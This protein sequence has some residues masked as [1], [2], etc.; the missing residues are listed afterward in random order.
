MGKLRPP[1]APSVDYQDA[2]DWLRGILWLDI[3]RRRNEIDESCARVANFLDAW[4]SANGGPPWVRDGS[5]R[6]SSWPEYCGGTR[7]AFVRAG[8]AGEQSLPD[9]CPSDFYAPIDWRD[10]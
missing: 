7:D 3:A 6:M 9:D 2:G 10:L 1:S 5:Q 8:V 4:E